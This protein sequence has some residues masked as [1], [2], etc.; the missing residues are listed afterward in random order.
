M[1]RCL[2]KTGCRCF[3]GSCQQEVP[4]FL[5]LPFLPDNGAEMYRTV[6]S[7]MLKNPDLTTEKALSEYTSDTEILYNL[8]MSA[9]LYIETY[10]RRYFKLQALHALADAGIHVEVYGDNWGNDSDYNGFVHIHERVSSAECN[11][12]AAR[13]KICLNFM[14]WF[15]DGAS[16]RVFNN[17]L[18]GSLCVS[19]PSF[20]LTEHYTDCKEIV[21]FDLKRMMDLP[22]RVKYYLDHPSEA[23][24]IA[25]AGRGKAIAEDTWLER[26]RTVLSFMDE[27]GV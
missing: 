25:E 19:D 8:N 7:K 23:A 18:A 3:C 26:M 27:D 21:Y 17:M 1:C 5:P 13:S 2:L 16:E 6:I 4:G 14:P 10:V 15:K 20:Y 22:L 9:A 24:A 12:L 11:R